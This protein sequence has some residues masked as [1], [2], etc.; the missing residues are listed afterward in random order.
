[1]NK[2]FALALV[3]AVITILVALFNIYL[4]FAYSDVFK[5]FGIYV[6]DGPYSF[7]QLHPDIA[8]F[9]TALS[10]TYGSV[11]LFAGIIGIIGGKTRKFKGG[12][13]LVIASAVSVIA[14]GLMAIV[15]FVLLL[16]SGVLAFMEG[17]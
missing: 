5:S 10:L 12:I 16:T 6:R 8:R 2:I 7:A 1:M 17:R 4:G 14:L 13:L 3:G 11:G 15:P 9:E